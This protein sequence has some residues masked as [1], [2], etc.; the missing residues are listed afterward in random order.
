VLL[1]TASMRPRLPARRGAGALLAALGA[2]IV[3][4]WIGLGALPVKVPFGGSPSEQL[5]FVL[6]HPHAFL[7]ALYHSFERLGYLYYQQFIG[8]IGWVDT[9]F[10]DPHYA[11]AGAALIGSVA[12]TVVGPGTGLSR[13]ERL[14]LAG[15]SLCAVG[16]IYV[17]QYLSWNPVGNDWIDGVHGRYFVPVACIL[18]LALPDL[19]ER[20]GPARRTISALGWAAVIGLAVLDLFAVPSVLLTRY[21][22]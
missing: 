15:A 17:L 13:T 21:H 20:A 19:G 12:A 11:L 2:L 8:V 10:S 7:A 9:Y 14:I 18:A 6:R 1:T 22:G 16:T 5:H 4:L 3:V